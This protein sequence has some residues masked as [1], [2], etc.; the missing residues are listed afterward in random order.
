MNRKLHIYDSLFG[1][2]NSTS[3]H[4]KP[5]N[6]EWERSH[7]PDLI[8]LSDSHLHLVNQI[9]SKKK[10]AW[11]IE[12]PFLCASQYQFI[13]SNHNKFHKVFTHNKNVL[14]KIPNGE[15]LPIGGCWINNED[16]KIYSKNKN[17][18]I[19]ASGKNSFTGHRLR[20]EII[21]KVTN[22][23][24]FGFAYNKLDNKIDGLKDYRF[25]ITVEN[26]K[27]DYYFTEKLIDCFVT[28]TIPIYWGCPSI[29]NFFDTN[30]IITF[31]TVGELQEILNNLEGV[32]ESKID[33]VKT[34]FNLAMTYR[35]GDDLVYE[36]IKN[37]II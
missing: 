32:Y 28:G 16:Q 27:E 34:N 35:V 20:H 2:A 29:G 4:N 13:I 23:D 11:L 30:G 26:A 19:I 14:Q 22:I 5:K 21:S 7:N 33:S 24:V 36:K 37:E 1:H 6:F 18:S 25:S 12:T 3:L 9:S 8:F 15:L 17:V 10:I 31:N